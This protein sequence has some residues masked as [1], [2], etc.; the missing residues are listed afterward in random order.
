[1][2]GLHWLLGAGALIAAGGVLMTQGDAGAEA[3]KVLDRVTFPTRASGVEITRETQRT[4][5]A[6]ATYAPRS[7]GTPPRAH[8]PLLVALS[9]AAEVALV[10]EAATILHA[11]V[12]QAMLA[13]VAPAAREK[14]DRPLGADGARWIDL[15]ERVAVS[16]AGDEKAMVVVEGK[17]GGIDWAQALPEA[18]AHEDGAGRTIYD[19]ERTETRHEWHATVWR[20]RL[21][22]GSPDEAPI[23]AALDRL[24]ADGESAP[25]AV[26]ESEAYGEVYGMVGRE[27]IAKL[28]PEELR[29]RIH[30]SARSA[31]IHVDAT[32]EVLLVADVTGDD[33]VEVED[34]GK[35]LG[36]AM[37]VGRLKAKNDGNDDL[38]R[39]LD[40]SRVRRFGDGAL[41]AEVAIPTEMMTKH[42]SGCR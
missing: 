13:C 18:T 29:D 8:D 21:A 23:E 37:A 22:L 42:M 38:V 10:F 28:V 27:T 26:G 24:D 16:K 40:A 19:V 36:V 25:L 35:S 30:E 32:D 3:H 5:L 34:L 12:G 39:L 20:D 33:A 4:T 6:P 31:M 41:R 11:P 7:D 17:L 1:M 14:M 9:P 15:A 2:R